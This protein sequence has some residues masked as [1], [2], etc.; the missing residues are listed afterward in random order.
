LQP[1]NKIEFQRGQLLTLLISGPIA[2]GENFEKAVAKGLI[3]K[4][5]LAA[6]TVLKRM[7]TTEEVAKVMAF[8]LSDDASYITGGN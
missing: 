1:R 2:T 3:D 5:V 4:K 7:G 8:L 6:G